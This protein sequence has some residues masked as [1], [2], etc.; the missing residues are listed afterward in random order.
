VI[1]PRR[2]NSKLS[3]EVAAVRANVV[4]RSTNETYGSRYAYWLD[5]CE[6]MER[7]HFM[8]P[9]WEDLEEFVSYLVYHTKL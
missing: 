8:N 9:T 6:Y 4:K 3:S 2:V 7:D 1:A 5:F